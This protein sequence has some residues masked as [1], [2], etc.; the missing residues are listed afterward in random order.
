MQ[1]PIFSREVVNLL[2]RFSGRLEAY[3]IQGLYNLFWFVARLDFIFGAVYWSDSSGPLGKSTP[4]NSRPARQ[5]ATQIQ[6][7]VEVLPASCHACLVLQLQYQYITHP[8]GPEVTSQLG[9]A[10]FSFGL[11]LNAAQKKPASRPRGGTFA[12]ETIAAGTLPGLV[13]PL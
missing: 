2:K 12:V 1:S 11:P 5:S 10:P 3:P 13:S 8:G 7:P 9:Q 6:S 4:Y